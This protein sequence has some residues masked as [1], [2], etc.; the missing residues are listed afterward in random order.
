M[1]TT[2]DQE[3]SA[4]PSFAQS[5]CVFCARGE[6][7]VAIT[8]PKFLVRRCSQCAVMWCDPL[9]F[10][11]VF[12]P[13]NEEAYLET[14]DALDGENQDRIEILMRAAPPSTHPTVLEVG[15]MHGDFLLRAAKEGYR[16]RGLDL[17]QTAV[18]HAAKT[19]PGLVE[20]GTLDERVAD[21]SVDVL[22]AFNVIEHMDAPHE[23]LAHAHR[24]LRPGGML[25]LETPRQESIFHHIMFSRGRIFTNDKSVD[26]GVYPG[27]HIFKFGNRAWRTILSDRDFEVT[28]LQGKSTPLSQL[29]AKQ[30]ISFA[31]RVAIVSFN[32]LAKATRL[33]NRLILTA[34]RT[35]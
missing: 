17:S 21:A 8:R 24:V 2:P 29:F 16:G 15:C 14:H 13:D 6:G 32:V 5:E 7:A 4:A 35:P 22:A 9:R 27:S 11:D 1:A 31:T 34:C 25:V 33:E 19:S 10:S 3:S 23:F 26:I 30:K 12:N 20:Y 18:D 28:S